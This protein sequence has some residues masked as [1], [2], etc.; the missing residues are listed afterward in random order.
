MNM[1]IEGVK[2]VWD[3]PMPEMFSNAELG[4]ATTGNLAM[5]NFTTCC[6]PLKEK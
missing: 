1:E 5:R 6:V 4:R 3:V 2:S